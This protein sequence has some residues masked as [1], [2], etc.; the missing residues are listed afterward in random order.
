MLFSIL[1]IINA[2]VSFIIIYFFLVGLQDGSVSSRN[3]RIWIMLLCAAFVVLTGSIWFKS[4]ANGR[5]A[6]ALLSV[7]ALPAF[8]YGIFMLVAI[9]GKVRWN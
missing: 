6:Y 4:H 3:I 7:F 9:F 8:F 2:I 1:W 5:V